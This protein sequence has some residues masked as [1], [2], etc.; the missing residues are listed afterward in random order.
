MSDVTRVFETLP[1]MFQKG[2]V[3]TARTFYFSLDDD[4]KWTVA[5]SAEKCEVN[6]GKPSQDADCFFKASTQMFLDVW[7]GKYTP[8]ATD[9]LMGKIKSNNPLLLKDFIAAFRK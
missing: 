5:L 4:E 8:S 3:K 6:R 1:K 2:N 7:N 9:F